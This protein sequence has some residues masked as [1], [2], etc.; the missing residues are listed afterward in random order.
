MPEKLRRVLL[1]ADTSCEAVEK[2]ACA[3]LTD[4]RT[5]DMP[6]DPNNVPIVARMTRSRLDK[7]SASQV[8][9]WRNESI[10]AIQDLSPRK[11]ERDGVIT[12]YFVRRHTH[13]APSPLSKAKPGTSSGPPP[14]S[15]PAST[16]GKWFS[17]K[18][19]ASARKRGQKRTKREIGFATP[20]KIIVPSP[21]RDVSYIA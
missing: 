15:T 2:R 19:P 16:P 8:S 11:A 6:A 9:K 13:E 21:D 1:R 7:M 4:S 5:I 10:K 18:K 3:S 17:K 20:S 12:Q 14:P